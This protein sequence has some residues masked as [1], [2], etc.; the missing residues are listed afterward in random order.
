MGGA[1]LIAIAIAVFVVL[2]S[3]QVFRDWPIA[4][5]GGGGD[6][7]AAVS[8]GHEVGAG[9]A[10]AG[11][12]AAPAGS[13]VVAR[14]GASRPERARA[15]VGD[16]ADSTPAGGDLATTGGGVPSA[17]TGAPG[18]GGG[19]QG[20][21]A[22][23]GS[24]QTPSSPTPGAGT[25]TGTASSGSGSGS[26][27]GAPGSGGG[28]GTASTPSGQVTETV[29]NTV[30]GV[31]EGA[32]GGTLGSTGVT[33]VTEGVVNGAAGPESVVGKV[34]DETVGVVGGLL[35]GKR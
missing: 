33:G 1:T 15:G 9:V 20:G 30:T 27:G 25:G 28:S 3:A 8:E 32:L 34:V 13:K 23:A 7:A 22:P 17:E 4:A 2:V 26:G 35:G 29:N 21:S 18:S 16:R 12:V 5:L 10:G 11:A 19:G 24:P 14:S 31:D 6:E